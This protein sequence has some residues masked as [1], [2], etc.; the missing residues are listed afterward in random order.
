MSHISHAVRTKSTQYR[1]HRRCIIILNE[2]TAAHQLKRN[3]TKGSFVWMYI[4]LTLCAR[5]TLTDSMSLCV[6]TFLFFCF[7][8]RSGSFSSSVCV[9][10]SLRMYSSAPSS[11]ISH[12]RAPHTELWVCFRSNLHMYSTSGSTVITQWFYLRFFFFVVCWC[13]CC[14]HL[15][16]FSVW[17]WWALQC[18]CTEHFGT[19]C[20]IVRKRVY[21]ARWNGSTRAFLFPS[22]SEKYRCWSFD[23]ISVSLE[24][25]NEPDASPCTRI[26]IF[27]R[28]AYRLTH[29]SAHTFGDD[30][31]QTTC[32]RKKPKI[33][34]RLASLESRA[35]PNTTN[36]LRVTTTKQTIPRVDEITNKYNK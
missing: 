10:A 1:S 8:L 13:C 28:G 24:L 23:T 26:D 30:D 9:R 4:H 17:Q 29:S 12:V 25:S 15:I 2:N 19:Y 27:F 11:T 16:Q 14:C 35:A 33:P 6:P 34:Y 18:F 36:L 32:S 7:Y 31:H 3:S 20:R 22:F 21:T 5:C